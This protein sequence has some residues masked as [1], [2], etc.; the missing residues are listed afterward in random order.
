MKKIIIFLSLLFCITF[1]GNA[2]IRF[3]AYFDGYWAQ[4]FDANNAQ[5]YGNYEGFVIHTKEEGPW[6][7]R[8]KFTIDNFNV[9]DKKQRKK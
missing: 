7:Y 6:N 8:F 5:I 9:P 1:D 2:Q 4:W 3:N